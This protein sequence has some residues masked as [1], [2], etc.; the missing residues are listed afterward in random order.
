[1]TTLVTGATG[2]VGTNLVRE[3]L[4]RG[5][6]VRALV[7]TE[8]AWLA[9]QGVE[10]VLGNTTDPES[11][12]AAFEGVEVV[13]HLAALVQVGQ[14]K[15]EQLF[16]TNVEGPRNVAAAAL[17]A[18]VK[19]MVHCSSCHALYEHPLHAPIDE[20]RALALSDDCLPYSRSKAEGELQVLEAVAEGLDAVICNPT[21]I[22]GPYDDRPSHLGELFIMLHQRS[23]PALIDATYDFVDVRDVVSGLLA[24]EEKGRKGERYLLSGHRVNVKQLA[25]WA[26]QATGV[27]SPTL[28]SPM[29]LA[30]LGAPFVAAW[31][32]L[33]NERPI[34]SPQALEVL[35]GNSDFDHGKATRELGYQPR[36]MK[37]TVQGFYDWY[38]PWKEAQAGAGSA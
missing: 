23:M 24:A 37:D 21:G 28:T 20:T 27:K 32:K 18:G 10:Q 8:S 1:M 33:R 25:G 9:E 31:A 15:A 12:P 38:L 17:A 4:A 36:P 19:R 14:V 34:Y 30:M 35:R 6:T 2:F 11:L 22:I 7:R 26:E 13:F 16:R 5:R 29:W 3:L